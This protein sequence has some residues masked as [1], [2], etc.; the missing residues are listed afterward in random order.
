M[1]GPQLR[2]AIPL[3]E[4]IRKK[5]PKI[6]IVWGGYFPSNHP[7]VVLNSGYVD[8]IINGP[9][10]KTFPALL[11]AFEC[12]QSYREIN[13]LIFK[14]GDEIIKTAKDEL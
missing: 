6:K 9:G 10:D 13:N 11:D 4:E 12:S 8:V 1:P 2:Q 5:F 14:L 3:S 7:K